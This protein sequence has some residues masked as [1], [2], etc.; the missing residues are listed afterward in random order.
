M[1]RLDERI[2][3]MVERFP[4]MSAAQIAA[5]IGYDDAPRLRGDLIRH[6]GDMSKR[7]LLVP[8]WDEQGNTSYRV[9][10]DGPVDEEEYDENPGGRCSDR[11]CG[12]CGRCV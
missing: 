2:M 12:S 10:A 4:G 9:A 11:S 6:V 5:R 1:S 7:G 8:S 3:A